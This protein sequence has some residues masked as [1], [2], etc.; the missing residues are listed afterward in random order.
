MASTNSNFNNNNNGDRD[1][2]TGFVEESLLWRQRGNL[3][4]TLATERHLSVHDIMRVTLQA[5]YL[6]Y[7]KT[8]K[9]KKRSEVKVGRT[10]VGDV[11]E[12]DT[13]LVALANV[14]SIRQ[15]YDLP[16]ELI[17]MASVEQVCKQGLSSAFELSKQ[18]LLD[19]DHRMLSALLKSM[20]R[21]LKKCY[22]STRVIADWRQDKDMLCWRVLGKIFE[23]VQGDGH[24]RL[25]MPP[26]LKHI[27]AWL[28]YLC[29]YLMPEC[30]TLVDPEIMALYAIS[31]LASLA[32][33]DP[34]RWKE[35]AAEHY[36]GHIAPL[37]TLV[38]EPSEKK[39]TMLWDTVVPR[40]GDGRF[41]WVKEAPRRLLL[42]RLADRCP[43]E[44]KG[45]EK[46]KNVNVYTH[47]DFESI[48]DPLDLGDQYVKVSSGHC[49]S[50]A[51]LQNQL[52]VSGSRSLD[53]V[54]RNEFTAKDI[55]IIQ[56]EAGNKASWHD[57]EHAL[58][59]TR[60]PGTMYDQDR[61]E[62]LCKSLQKNIF[63]TSSKA[64]NNKG[65]SLLHVKH[66]VHAEI[67]AHVVTIRNLISTDH[68]YVVVFLPH[69]YAGNRLVSMIFAIVSLIR[70]RG[71]A[72]DFVR[73]L[74]K[75][76]P[77]KKEEAAIPASYSMIKSKTQVMPPSVLY[78]VYAMYR[79]I[80]DSQ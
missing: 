62:S 26:E 66:E 15:H 55:K 76:F 80:F 67:L 37:L 7:K 21:V 8:Y 42:Q 1:D 11:F 3:C 78:T 47:E 14:E 77:G 24:H 59:F 20:K 17:S 38:H 53:P 57:F 5:M 79:M 34:V 22:I 64:N 16:R 40:V 33:N 19:A 36:Y 45:E 10:N 54:G 74:H 44:V 51:G 65:P 18:Q 71:Q 30:R 23:K 13:K 60:F 70:T 31:S 73:I 4:H 46:G 52:K 12:R 72:E 58:A 28:T 75:S 43:Y 49:Y 9:H 68:K 32:L 35:V 48:E 63:D 25:Y 6:I 50:L 41:A 56:S 39:M 69:N 2:I 61:M 27:R 29:K